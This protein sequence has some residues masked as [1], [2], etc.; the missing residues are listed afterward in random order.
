[1]ADLTDREAEYLLAIP[2][3]I[4]ERLRWQRRGDARPEG[5]E[6][7]ATII[8]P[9]DP[10]LDRSIR[11]VAE[12]FRS[13][14]GALVWS[15]AIVVSGLKPP[16]IRVDTHNK[17]HRNRDGSLIR[18]CMMHTWTEAEKDGLAVPAGGIIDCSGVDAALMSFLKHCNISLAEP[19]Q[20]RW[21]GGD[22][23]QV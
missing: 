14:T 10:D 15:V 17:P 8:A 13:R 22:Y 9:E 12:C 20:I 19:Y 16:L 21:D 1:M 6:L 18:G 23:G 7:R 11:L 3:R 4:G 2:K 5:R